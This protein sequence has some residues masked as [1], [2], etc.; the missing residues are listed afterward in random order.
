MRVGENLIGSVGEIGA[1]EAS[2]LTEL[3]SN[4]TRGADRA[5]KFLG[6]SGGLLW[7]ECARG[8]SVGLYWVRLG[9]GGVPSLALGSDITLGS[10]RHR[11]RQVADELLRFLA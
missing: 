4:S 11:G 2:E 1:E 8:S 3:V 6:E 10:L 5:A 9:G 7:A